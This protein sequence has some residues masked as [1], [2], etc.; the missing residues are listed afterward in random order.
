MYTTESIKYAARADIGQTSR[1]LVVEDEELI[2]EMLAVALEEEGFAVTT[3][4]DGRSAMEYLKSCEANSGEAGFDLIILDLMLPHINGLDI[5]RLLRHQGNPVPILILSAK[6]SETDR[7]LGLEVGADDYLTKPFSMREL[8]ARCRAL[9]RRQRLSSL[10]QLQ[11]L[12]HKNVTLN[13]QE[14]R[15]LVRGQEV[16]LSPKEFRLLELFMSYARRVWSREQLL[17]QVWGPDFVGDSKTVDVHIRWLREKLEE[18]PSHPE[19]IVTV[20]GFGYRFG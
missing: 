4:P 20:R 1:I 6:G 10:P 8:V 14:C 19:Y 15:V 2:Q 16:N 5:C 17:D 11:V 18:D 12:K 13:P 3:A 9:L 7:V